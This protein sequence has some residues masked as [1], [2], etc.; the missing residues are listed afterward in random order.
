MKPEKIRAKLERIA[1][2]I[3]HDLESNTLILTLAKEFPEKIYIPPPEPK[4][5]RDIISFELEENIKFL[6]ET[7]LTKLFYNRCEPEE[8]IEIDALT[9]NNTNNTKVLNLAKENKRIQ[10]TLKLPSWLGFIA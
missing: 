6:I 2:Y 10:I 5:K 3:K 8:Q 4:P 1:E 7:S 9:E